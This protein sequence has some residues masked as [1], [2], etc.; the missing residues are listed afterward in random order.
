MD[1]PLLPMEE[2][3]WDYNVLLPI[4]INMNETFY[5]FSANSLQ[6]RQVSMKSFV[7][8]TVL[9]VNTASACGFTPQYEGLQKLYDKYKDDKFVIL[10]FPCNQFGGQEPGTADDIQ[11]GCLINYGVTFPMFEKIDV[12]GK[13]AHPIY[14]WLKKQ[15]GGLLGSRIKWNFTKFLIDPNG[16][17]VKRYGSIVKPE[18]IEKD[19]VEVIEKAKWEDLNRS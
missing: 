14:Q 8:K 4:I 17:V 10:G 19:I 16:H 9:V 15:K 12:N 2:Q 3:F 7:T 5:Y 11:E 6:G 18:A 13:K 1:N